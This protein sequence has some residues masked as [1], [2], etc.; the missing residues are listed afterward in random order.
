[1]NGWV[2][3]WLACPL[4]WLPGSL[5]GCLAGVT[6]FLAALLGWLSGWL[7][8]LAGCLASRLG[9][10]AWLAGRVAADAKLGAFAAIWVR[11]A[12]ACEV[13]ARNSVLVGSVG[14]AS[15]VTASKCSELFDSTRAICWITAQH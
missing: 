10:A 11:R 4:S 14:G 12:P 8:G 15:G 1:M 13:L 2:A 3:G 5:V 9:L 7:A 6:G